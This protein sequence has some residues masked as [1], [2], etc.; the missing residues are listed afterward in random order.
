[1]PHQGPIGPCSIDPTSVPHETSFVPYVG[2]KAFVEPDPSLCPNSTRLAFQFC[3]WPTDG[4]PVS[5][6]QIQNPPQCIV[7]CVILHDDVSRRARHNGLKD[8]SLG[9]LSQGLDGSQIGRGVVEF[10]GLR[11]RLCRV[12]NVLRQDACG[13]VSFL[14]LKFGPPRI[15][16]EL[17]NPLGGLLSGHDLQLSNGVDIGQRPF[18]SG[19][20]WNVVEHNVPAPRSGLRIEVV[21]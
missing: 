11:P 18:L 12:G 21:L 20:G 15:G 8:L 14:F 16:L 10:I 17:D 9:I 1:M 5:C 19:K 4:L 6:P 7:P 3:P 13:N 2:H